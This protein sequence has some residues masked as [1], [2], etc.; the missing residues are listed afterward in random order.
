MDNSFSALIVGASTGWK[1]SANFRQV[2]FELSI[3]CFFAKLFKKL[4]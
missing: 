1:P 2:E 3:F 4:I